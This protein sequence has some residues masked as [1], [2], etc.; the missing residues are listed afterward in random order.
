MIKG[1]K[2]TE[3]MFTHYVLFFLVSIQSAPP[4]VVCDRVELFNRRSYICILVLDF[5]MT[6]TCQSLEDCFARG[7]VLSEQVIGNLSAEAFVSALDI[8]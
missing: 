8:P 5:T 7:L 3:L 6:W 2:A 4:W 1:L